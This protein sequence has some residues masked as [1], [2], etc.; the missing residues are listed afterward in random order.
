MHSSMDLP[1]KIEYK[2]LE[3]EKQDEYSNRIV[4]EIDNKKTQRMKNNR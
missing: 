2:I 1:D 3:K 4:Y